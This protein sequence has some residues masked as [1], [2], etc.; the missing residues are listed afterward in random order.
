SGTLTRSEILSVSNQIDIIKLLRGKSRFSKKD[1]KEGGEDV[2]SSD[3]I[4]TYHQ[5]GEILSKQYYN[6][7]SGHTPEEMADEWLE[8]SS[9]SLMKDVPL[10]CLKP[11]K[12]EEPDDLSHST[13]PLIID[14]N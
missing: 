11:Y 4:L 10:W 2:S 3:K 9:Y 12:Y 14:G 13:G 7:K 1:F 5:V 8:S 6:K